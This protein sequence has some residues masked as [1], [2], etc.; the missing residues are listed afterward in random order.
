[1][2]SLRATDVQNITSLGS[3]VQNLEQNVSKLDSK[4]DGVEGTAARSLKEIVTK[5]TGFGNRMDEFESEAFSGRERVNKISESVE[6]ISR[7]VQSLESYRSETTQKIHEVELEERKIAERSNSDMSQIKNQM[8]HMEEQTNMRISELGKGAQDIVVKITQLEDGH[9]TQMQKVSLIDRLGE[10]VNIMDEQRQKSEAA[11]RDEVDASMNKSR[12]HLEHLE[13]RIQETASIQTEKITL[14][15]SMR[16]KLS[17]VEEDQT[18]QEERRRVELREAVLGNA[19]EIEKLKASV[20]TRLSEMSQGSKQEGEVIQNAL[21]SLE[22][23]LKKV[24]E[25]FLSTE[26]EIHS[27]AMSYQSDLDTRLGQMSV[28]QQRQGVELANMSKSILEADS[29]HVGGRLDKYGRHV[30]QIVDA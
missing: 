15:E 22:Q 7:T 17:K 21:L 26:E 23:N 18:E 24:E 6:S 20:D 19:S 10:R 30:G 13:K 29:R 16:A 5:V 3:S 27:N 12:Q 1:M 14:M 9:M 4:V 11:A 8:K 2:N 25:R 28:E